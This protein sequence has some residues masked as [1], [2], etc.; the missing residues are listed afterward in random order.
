MEPEHLPTIDDCTAPV[1]EGQKE[2]TAV[3]QASTGHFYKMLKANMLRV[4]LTR[5][6]P[7]QVS[8]QFMERV[9]R[10]TPFRFVFEGKEVLKECDII[11]ANHQGPRND[12]VV[13]V[14]GKLSDGVEKGS[15]GTE[16]LFVQEL[17]PDDRDVRFVLKGELTEISWKN[18]VQNLRQGVVA[19]CKQVLMAKAARKT[20]PIIVRRAPDKEMS[21]NPGEGQGRHREYV[22]IMRE[23]RRRVAKEIMDVMSKGTP[24]FMYPE[25]MRSDDGKIL[26]FVSEYFEEMIR[27]YVVPRLCDGRPIRIGLVVA[28]MLRAFPN[29]IGKNVTAYD[30][31][32]TLKGIAYDAANI[33]HALRARAQLM[34]EQPLLERE[35]K[36][37]GRMFLIDARRQME[38]ALSHIQHRQ[39]A[40]ETG[41]RTAA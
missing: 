4:A 18:F 27:S 9:S 13:A 41:E 24:V 34:G 19:A 10:E 3:P 40:D 37:Y 1:C 22:E 12:E 8:H 31:P 28:D 20:H 14:S 29:G 15:G 16:A 23:E 26:G 30:E 6:D 25:G 35:V 11:L 5:C 33:E 38:E 2:K 39:H 21:F 32:I 17:L 36:H 7:R